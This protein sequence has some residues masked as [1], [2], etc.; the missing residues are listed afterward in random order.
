MPYF[1]YLLECKDHSFY[2]GYTKDINRRI[3]EHGKGIGSKYTRAR[4]PITLRYVEDQPT[5][6]AALKREHA[7]KQFSRKQ[8]ENLI[9]SKN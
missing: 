7:I 9:L 2:C 3:K 1:V 5:L 6:S 4:R 8:K